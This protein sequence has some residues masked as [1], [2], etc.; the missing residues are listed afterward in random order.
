LRGRLQAEQR[1]R[2]QCGG[3]HSD[4]ASAGPESLQL[5]WRLAGVAGKL[6]VAV[7]LLQTIIAIRL[8]PVLFPTD[9]KPETKSVNWLFGSK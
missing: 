3:F 8:L 4:I 2:I 6:R 7:K 9:D 5:E 1:Q